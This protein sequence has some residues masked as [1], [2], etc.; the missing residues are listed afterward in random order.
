[1][2]SFAALEQYLQQVRKRWQVTV[3]S[4]GLGIAAA[5]ALILTVIC[6]IV[7]NRFAFSTL[8]V[9]SGRAVLYIATGAVL[10]LALIRPLLALRRRGSSSPWVQRMGSQF[11]AFGE[12]IETFVD[13]NAS[14]H[15]NPIMELLA[16]D[17]MKLAAQAPPEQIAS[18]GPILTFS[19]VALVALAVLIWLGVA[20]PGYLGYGTA[21]LWGGWLK[22]NVSNLYQISVDPGAATVRRRADLLIT[23]RLLGF[24]SPT[25]HLYAKYASSSKWEEAPMVRRPD[26]SGFEFQFAGVDESLRY[27][28]SAGSVKSQEY[29]VKVVEMPNVKKLRL[30]YHFP[31]WTGIAPVTQEPGGDIR[32]VAGTEVEVQVETDRPLASGTLQVD[33]QPSIALRSD[34]N[35]SRGTITVQK[36]G[37]YFVAALYNGEVVRLS[38]DYF[39]E[40]V[41]DQPPTVKVVRPG[42]DAKATAIEE[43]TAQFEADDDFGLKSFDLHYSVNGAQ[44]KTVPLNAKGGKQAGASH[45]FALEDFKLVPGD[46][47]SYY[48][49]ARDAKV[50]TKTDMYF[51]EVQPFEL[52]YYQSQQGGGGGGGGGDDD[53]SQISRRQKE[54]V[55]ATWNLARDKKMDKQKAADNA[56]TLSGV[57]SK[58]RDQANTLA[59]R[60]KK[61]QL[62]DASGEFKAFVKNMEEASAA[63]SPAADKLKEQKWEEAMAPEQKALQY[64]LRAEAIFR[65][66]QVAF[67][68]QGGGGGG[69]M[70]RDLSDMFNLELDT[71]KNQYETGQQ[72]SAQERDKEL[73][74][75]LEKLRELARRQEQLAEQQKRQQLPSFDQRWQQEMLR[76]EAEELAKQLQQMQIGRASCRERV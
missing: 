10:A 36:D 72:A 63:M 51:V 62:A 23:A 11:P 54:I 44:E 19:G 8:S 29:D 49:V 25:A 71:E 7:A 60:M 14:E 4:R 30:T 27:Y 37:R 68:N 57:Q 52:E 75:A 48:A 2:N 33:G 58:L 15:R 40:A 73:D 21:R 47:I 65:Q 74:S 50:E 39:I 56:K 38:D 46:V 69:G 3:A 16:E 12:R 26:D 61:R 42:R 41:A 64:L 28:V 6:V 13:K 17:T 31:S 45:M 32:A 55:A 1:M 9:I 35:L 76:R 53:G 24:Y 66:I 59:E 18:S 5:A 70:G 34:A 67:G 43:V 22:S 20:G